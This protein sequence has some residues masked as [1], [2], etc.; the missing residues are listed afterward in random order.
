MRFPQPLNKATCYSAG[1]LSA[2]V[3]WSILTDTPPEA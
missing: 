1:G 2:F 3:N